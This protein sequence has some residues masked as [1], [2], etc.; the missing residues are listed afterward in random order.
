MKVEI[1]IG[2]P[3]TLVVDDE[4][5]EE[6][7]KS[8]LGEYLGKF[9]F[10]GATEEDVDVVIEKTNGDFYTRISGEEDSGNAPADPVSTK[11]IDEEEP[12][13]LKNVLDKD[14][15]GK[16]FDN[17]DISEDQEKACSEDD[18]IC[19]DEPKC[20]ED[21]CCCE[22]DQAELSRFGENIALLKLYLMLSDN[23]RWEELH[24]NYGSTHIDYL[25]KQ[26]LLNKLFVQTGLDAIV[27]DIEK[28]LDKAR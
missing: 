24:T 13:N 5:L 8:I 25:E 28:T 6:L 15:Q 22:E 1:R 20:C 3:K 2:I 4:E 19:Y 17:S 21:W 9:V 16:Y 18:N 7:K 12:I 11:T 14:A 27:K 26:F 23:H 10:I